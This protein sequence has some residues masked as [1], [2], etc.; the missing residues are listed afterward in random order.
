[1]N[2]LGVTRNLD[3]GPGLSIATV[4]LKCQN[5]GEGYGELVQKEDQGI[6]RP[7]SPRFTLVV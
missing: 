1:M 7:G 5:R 3:V 2:E 4:T 6:P